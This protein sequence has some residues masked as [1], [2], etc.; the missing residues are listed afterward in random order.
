MSATLNNLPKQTKCLKFHANPVSCDDIIVATRRKICQ[1]I[2]AVIAVTFGIGSQAQARPPS[3]AE[4]LAATIMAEE[5]SQWILKLEKRPNSIGIFEVRVGEPLGSEYATLVES[6]LM[7]QF[8]NKNEVKLISC[9][10]CRLPQVAVKGDKLVVTRGMPDANAIQEFGKSSQM[11]SVLNIEIMRTKFNVIGLFTLYQA[12]NAQIVA[13]KVFKV[14]ALDFG[15]A[16]FQ[17]MFTGGTGIP[18]GGKESGPKDPSP[19]YL[20]GTLSLLEEIG[21]GK[22][23]IAIGGNFSALKGNLLYVLPT[24]GFRSRMGATGLYSLT[25]VGLGYGISRGFGGIAV[26]GAYQL[27]LGTFTTLGIEATFFQPI[28]RS[29]EDSQNDSVKGSLGVN[30]GIALGR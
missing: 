24:L 12:N 8:S 9:I 4:I 11:E 15:D 2:G 13:S 19:F 29:Q 1:L 3:E 20:G 22:G 18:L 14:P 28:S 27:F 26:R 10:E 16:A 17:I 5:V 6:T 21:M 23:G 7:S 25:T 30:L